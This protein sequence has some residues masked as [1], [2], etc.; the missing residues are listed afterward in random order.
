MELQELCEK[1]TSESTESENMPRPQLWRS[2]CIKCG[3][4]CLQC[5]AALLHIQKRGKRVRIGECVFET[6]ALIEPRSLGMVS[7]ATG[8]AL[9]RART[10]GVCCAFLSGCSLGS[11]SV[12]FLQ[13]RLIRA[14]AV[15]GSLACP[16]PAR[17]A[18]LRRDSGASGKWTH[19]SQ[20]ARRQTIAPQPCHQLP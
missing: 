19:L 3:R 10:A 5:V 4:R 17:A 11:R 2:T 14:P 1:A 18:P 13:G 6:G 8:R 9:R 15:R 12:Y 16:S 20:T 7:A